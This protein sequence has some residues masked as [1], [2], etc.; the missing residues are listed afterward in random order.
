MKKLLALAVVILGFTAVSFGQLNTV[1]DATAT[2]TILGPLTL[3]AQSALA[4]GALSPTGT[5][6]TVIIDA[7]GGARAGSNVTLST[8]IPNAPAN[9]KVFGAF[10]ATYAIT[11]PADNTVTIGNGV[12]ADNMKV[13][14]FKWSKP[15]LNST[16]DAT[17]NDV[18]KVGATLVVAAN[19]PV[20]SYTGTYSVTVN[21][22]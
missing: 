5:A 3:T 18:F 21:Y 13:N 1:A 12:P 16:L 10:N 2:A 9:F 15:A 17:G 20:G 22:N 4:F 11:L 14:S 7:N 8:I 6:G 19:Q